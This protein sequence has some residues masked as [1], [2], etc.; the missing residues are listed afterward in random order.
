M[1]ISTLVTGNAFQ[2]PAIS[3]SNKQNDYKL[4]KISFLLNSKS[5]MADLGVSMSNLNMQLKHMQDI[6]KDIIKSI[7]SVLSTITKLDR[8]MTVRF[9][10]LN[11]EISDSRTEF[12]RSLAGIAPSLTGG[13]SAT[14]SPAAFGPIAPSAAAAAA[15][16]IPAM[17]PSG[18][19]LW[20]SFLTWLA[21]NAAS[22]YL[23][24]KIGAKLATMGIMATVPVAG[25]VSAAVSFAFI[26]PDLWDLY[27]F[28]K[29]FRGEQGSAEAEAAIKAASA[30]P[31]ASVP[32]PTGSPQ[33][34]AAGPAGPAPGGAGTPQQSSAGAGTGSVVEK[35]GERAAAMASSSA[36]AA[37]STNAQ[38]DAMGNVTVPA[39]GTPAAAPTKPNTSVAPEYDAMGNVTVPGFSAT[40]SGP[41]SVV[42]KPGERAAANAPG[43]PLPPRRPANLGA[44]AAKPAPPIDPHAKSR[45]MFQ[46]VLDMEKNGENSTAMYFAADKQRQLELDNL[47]KAASAPGAP[48]NVKK[49]AAKAKSIPEPPRRP[50]GLGEIQGPNLPQGP[51]MPGG[52]ESAGYTGKSGKIL[53]A[54][55][56][57]AKYLEDQQ[58][59]DA[60]TTS[61]ARQDID[62]SDIAR[63]PGEKATMAADQS[64]IAAIASGESTPAQVGG[65]MRQAAAGLIQPNATDL[66][67]GTPS[68]SPV[69]PPKPMIIPENEPGYSGK[70][71]KILQYNLNEYNATQTSKGGEGNN[72]AGQNLPLTTTN[73]WIQEFIDRQAISYQ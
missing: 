32:A 42:E 66:A 33:Q 28:W 52:D 1:A 25:W 30:A 61:Q 21:A 18:N 6:S 35:P 5:S 17:P 73:P 16:D 27:Q 19:S 51:Q 72:V 36:A 57:E 26:L 10:R 14:V 37:P 67:Q 64:K 34:T 24:K 43:A 59:K 29:Q 60:A 8:D 49:A 38:Y 40:G 58:K 22:K 4:E 11:K 15:S 50:E 7:T 48:A 69:V 70:A 53:Q 65:T 45:A 68:A 39:A 31:A 12:T 63:A 47:K 23:V 54:N 13:S 44:P 9:R 20:D 55:L 62:D 41:G 3:F 46:Q 2:R 56:D 71:G